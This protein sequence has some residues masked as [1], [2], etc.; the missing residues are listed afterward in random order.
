M[1]AEQ[2]R[3]N[4][5]F[6]RKNKSKLTPLVV[7]KRVLFWLVV[8]LI[9]TPLSYCGHAMINQPSSWERYEGA[10]LAHNLRDV[11]ICDDTDKKNPRWVTDPCNSKDIRLRPWRN[12][13]EIHIYALVSG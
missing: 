7:I 12:G 8:L 13:A 10:L 3:M 5:V 4:M 2:G 1:L 6:K 11:F 9:V